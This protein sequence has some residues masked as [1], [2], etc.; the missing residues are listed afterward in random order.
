M[1]LTLLLLLPGSLAEGLHTPIPAVERGVGGD[2]EESVT[3]LLS[4]DPLEA[5]RGAV[6]LEKLRGSP[7]AGE[8]YRA[9]VLET[10]DESAELRIRRA[11]I[12]ARIAPLEQVED[13]ISRLA[14]PD[15]AV[16][17][18]WLVFL[19][20]A[21]HSSGRLEE[22]VRAIEGLARSDQDSQLRR[23]ARVAL[24]RMD[25]DESVASLVRLIDVL[26]TPEAAHAAAQLPATERADK[27]LRTLVRRGVDGGRGPDTT[28]PAVLAA[29]LPAYGAL[30]GEGEGASAERVAPILTGLRHTSPAVRS[31][32]A[33]AFDRLIDRLIDSG[34][35]VRALGLLEDLAGIGL[36]P[37]QVHLQ[38][39]RLALSLAGDTETALTSARR[40]RADL[41]I[42]RAG[43]SLVL[44]T[45]GSV[46]E[47]RRWLQRSLLLEAYA[48][49][50]AGEF[51]SAA[52]GLSRAAD[53]IDAALAEGELHEAGSDEES[54]EWDHAQRLED[55]ALVEVCA[56][57]VELARGARPSDEVLL[58]RAR[59][60]HRLTLEIQ[61]RAARL[62]GEALFG[63]DM[64]LDRDL[65][66]H[67]LLFAGQAVSGWS[68]ARAIELQAS[69]GRVLASV[70]P[71]ELPGFRPVPDLPND[72]GDPLVD[73][74]RRSLLEELQLA[75]LE[76]L[77]EKI[78]EVHERIHDRGGSGWVRPE[79][80]HRD[81]QSLHWKRSRLQSETLQVGPA[82]E[83]SLS[84]QRLPGGQALWLARELRT[85]GRGA[86]ARTLAGR[87][88]E[89][90]EANGISNWWYSIGIERVVRA[91]LLIGSSYTDDDE[92]LRA[93]E[94]LQG[95]AARLEG[96][97]RRMEDNGASE[98]DLR[99]YR[100]LRSNVLVSLAVNSNVKK[101]DPDEA[102]AYYEQAFALRKDEFMRVLLAC[103]RARSG[104]A[105]E[106]RDLLR[107]V[108]PGPQTWY[109]LA[110]TYALLG[111]SETAI[112]YL[113]LEL[114]NH[115]SEASRRRQKA[116]AR[117][118]PD[119]ASLRGDPRFEALLGD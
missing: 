4:R 61:V 87:F 55:R 29:C 11:A 77:S 99:H 111:E 101:G 42:E 60:A 50:A 63:W 95:A 74:L 12:A 14:D 46:S 40:L 51:D 52:E 25:R 97:E 39:A 78:D 56:I 89:D 106:A 70:A 76:G 5:R 94:V 88:K 37:R 32:S 71:L 18:Q 107:E 33:R 30:L 117:D 113:R 67:R 13:V 79:Q 112:G 119:L 84:E 73:P 19:D 53:I 82:R 80:A 6:E 115:P 91:E 86:E 47:A 20:R 85:E 108:R 57:L 96:L 114:E 16:R 45:G 36:E 118:D 102:L 1:I 104:R 26:P 98:W 103:Y 54:G 105:Q 81:L 100:T 90:L 8:V 48:W 75:R 62:A 83:K 43:A 22:R 10:G 72:L 64:L 58:E 15:P 31:A 59:L 17:A 9:L 93:E 38:R 35:S 109:N 44:I 69:L 34:A 2:W 110:C 21:D 66:P 116:W 41:P 27:A 24:G 65:G 49:M 7:E 68:S 28:A 92:P 3:L 23:E